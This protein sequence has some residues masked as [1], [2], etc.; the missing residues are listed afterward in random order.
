MRPRLAPALLLLAACSAASCARSADGTTVER[1]GGRLRERPYA[2]ATAYEAYLRGELAAA[3]G[4]TMSG[5]EVVIHD[6]FVSR[7]HIEIRI[8]PHGVEVVD[9]RQQA[10]PAL[11]RHRSRRAGDDRPRPASR[12][13]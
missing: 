12:R 9:L 11:P 10:V 4:A 1:I 5:N 3:R 2:S 8:Y 7:T 13:A 6:P